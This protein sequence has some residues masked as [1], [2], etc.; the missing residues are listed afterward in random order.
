[1]GTREKNPFVPANAGTQR[2]MN[3]THGLLWIPAVACARA[4][5]RLNPSTGMN[6]EGGVRGT[7]KKPFVPANAGTQ[8]N[9]SLD[10]RIRGDERR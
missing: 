6:G 9:I 1:M 4:S 7:N 2:H 8:D 10:P 3:F 5:R